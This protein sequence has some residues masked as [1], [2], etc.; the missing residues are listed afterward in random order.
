MPNTLQHLVPYQNLGLLS[1]RDPHQQGSRLFHISIITLDALAARQM[2]PVVDRIVEQID[3]FDAQAKHHIGEAYHL[4]EKEL[5]TLKLTHLHV[6]LS[7]TFELLYDLPEGLPFEYVSAHF[8]A[9]HMFEA[10]GGGNY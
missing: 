7:G 6:K 8:N 9:E 5:K 1:T 3:H 4:T 10:V 2:Q